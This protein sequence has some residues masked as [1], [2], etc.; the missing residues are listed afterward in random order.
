MNPTLQ[1]IQSRRSVRRFK[2][3]QISDSE[4]DTVI[5]AGRCA[6]S[7]GNNQSC[8][9]IVVQ[10]RQVLDKLKQLAM[11]QFSSMELT[12]DTYKSIANSIRA[13]QKGTYDFTY[14]A[15]TLIIVSNLK[16]YGNA[17]ADSACLLE[18]MMLAAHSIG[19]G[20]CW[21]NQLHWLDENPVMKAYLAELGLASEETVCGSLA[22]G[23]PAMPDMPPA[24]RKG[25]KVSY[26][27]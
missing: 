26:I 9:I 18:N 17:M 6:P 24:I 14:G 8:H 19:L 22:L 10:K 13:S 12:P 25:N 21:L 3:E 7:G 1:T 4:L 16:G 5:Q 15:P 11:Q 20:S 27:V 2:N 23:Y